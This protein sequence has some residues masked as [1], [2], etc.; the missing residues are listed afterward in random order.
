MPAGIYF[1]LLK[2]VLTCTNKPL[3]LNGTIQLLR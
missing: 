2:T 1:Y 3:E